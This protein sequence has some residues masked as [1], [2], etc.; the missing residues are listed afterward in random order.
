MMTT[1]MIT[2]MIKIIIKNSDKLVVIIV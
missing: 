1:I 2:K